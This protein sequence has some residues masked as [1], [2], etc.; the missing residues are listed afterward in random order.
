MLRTALKLALL[1]S[2]TLLGLS[3]WLAEA[4]PPA[5]AL[6]PT[7]LAEPLQ[8][9]VREPAFDTTIGGITYTV[10]PLHRY[11]IS[12][13]VVSRHDALGWR[14][15]IHRDW[16]DKLNVADICVV[17]G[18]NAQSG[19]YLPLRFWNG[20]FTCNWEAPTADSYSDFD[21]TAISNNHLLAANA[22]TVRRIRAARVG[23]QIR[24]T[25]VLA[26]YSH[27]H[28]FAFRRGTSTTRSDSGNGACETI[29]VE[30]FRILKTGGTPWRSL[31]WVA[32]GLLIL[33]LLG[34]FFQPARFND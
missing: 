20:Q 1:G 14:D 4:L 23:D 26:E 7:L 17:W 34:W 21:P 29:Y 31:R 10:K 2:L 22:H 27:N 11:E 15:Y 30:D 16:H 18:S 32:G 5:A 8:R 12:G 9:A 13:L 3:L 24:I 28:G 19:A 25:G 33:S 6:D